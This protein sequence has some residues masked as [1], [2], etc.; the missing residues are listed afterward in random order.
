MAAKNKGTTRATAKR[1]AKTSFTE[2]PNCGID[3]EEKEKNKQK[4]DSCGYPK[5][6][7]DDIDLALGFKDELR[8]V[9]DED[10]EFF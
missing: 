3:W 2:C 8:E 10:D 7:V 4:C 5:V 1:T 9:D 6:K